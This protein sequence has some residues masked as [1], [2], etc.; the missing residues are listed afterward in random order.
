MSY[1][2]NVFVN[3]DAL[4]NA[5]KAM[6]A[7]HYDSAMKDQSGG[8]ASMPTFQGLSRQ[9][10]SGLLG[11]VIYAMAKSAAPQIAKRIGRVSKKVASGVPVRKAIRSEATSFLKGKGRKKQRK[12]PKRRVKKRTKKRGTS[13]KKRRK[14]TVKNTSWML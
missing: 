12:K 8:G 5:S 9:K 4:Y 3:P 10:G 1:S 11:N 7:G 13:I 14:K 6:S 2:D